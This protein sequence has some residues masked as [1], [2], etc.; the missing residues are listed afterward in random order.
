MA[1][2][3]HTADDTMA[4]ADA[5]GMSRRSML[6][7]LAGIAAVPALAACATGGGQ[8]SG[9]GQASERL[10]P[11]GFTFKQPVQL[12]YWKSL[13]GPRHEAQVKLTDDFNASRQDVKVALEHVGNY[14]QGAEKFT[15][16]LAANTPPD[17][18]MLT[19]DTF[20]PGFARMGAL[21]PLDEYGKAD[22]SAKMETYVPGFIK[23]GTING[24]LFQVPLARSTPVLY[25]NKDH[26]RSAGLPE[27]PPNTWEQVLDLA[28]KLTRSAPLQPDAADGL[29]AAFPV[30]G[31]WWTFQAA[32]WAF[33]GKLSDDKFVPSVTQ[34]ET[35]QAMQFLQDMVVRHRVARAYRTVGPSSTAFQQGQLSFLVESTAVL[36]E[37]QTKT[38]A[39]VG[40]A[41]MPQQK[42]R[43]V[44]GGGAGLSIVNSIPVEKKEAGWEF[45]KS[46]TTT[47]NTV[48]FSKMTGYMVVRT[49]AEKNQ[50]FQ[51]YLKQT[52]NAKVTFDQM[53]FVR[54]QDSIGEAPGAPAAIEDS[55]REV[56]IEGKNVKTVLE[57][58][59]RKLTNLAAEVRK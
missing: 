9:A 45:M 33:G 32:T 24:K 46:I 26:F 22:K 55:I 15:A 53:Q 47:P 40:A 23:N 51:D 20:M 54:T 8:G 49:D 21:Q 37:V 28:Q 50:E 41:F 29:K 10:G 2:Q 13:E 48:Y 17:V 56:M 16:V 34:P 38:A 52:P 42:Q 39:Q 27:T 19:V 14:A 12:T 25:Y 31:Y 59:Q 4:P 44:P 18:M 36:S 57:E 43:A 6:R 1:T 5:A 58:L 7:T 35:V 3:A 30:A 11:N